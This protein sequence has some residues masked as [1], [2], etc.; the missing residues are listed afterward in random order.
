MFGMNAKKSLVPRCPKYIDTWF[1]IP[2]GVPFG[3][4]SIF[5]SNANMCVPSWVD[6]GSRA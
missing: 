2:G 4:P 6:L 5:L 1:N 3:E